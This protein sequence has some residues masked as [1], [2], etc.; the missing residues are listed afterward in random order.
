MAA[1]QEGTGCPPA[2]DAGEGAHPGAGPDVQVPDAPVAADLI[3]AVL[4]A[5]ELVV[6]ALA[7]VVVLVCR[8]PA[9]CQPVAARVPGGGVLLPGS[10]GAGL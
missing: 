5:V 7:A 9:A 10:A 4:I 3:A 2:A 1:G 8:V 6:E